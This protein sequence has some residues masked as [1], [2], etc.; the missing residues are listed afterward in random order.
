MIEYVLLIWCIIITVLLIAVIRCQNNQS[1][2]LQILNDDILRL[3][4][5][6][7]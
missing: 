6:D 1:E 3:R 4:D 7:T 5:D 2:I